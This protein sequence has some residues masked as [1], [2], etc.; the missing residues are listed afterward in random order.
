MRKLLLEHLKSGNTVIDIA[1]CVKKP[2]SVIHIIKRYIH[3]Y[4]GTENFENAIKPSKR[5]IF[6]NAD[7][8]YNK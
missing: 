3:T 4:V 5:K 2:I 7:E 1:E 8:R 6:C